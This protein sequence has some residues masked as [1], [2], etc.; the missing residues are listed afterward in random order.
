MSI[1]YSFEDIVAI[2]SCSV[3]LNKNSSSTTLGYLSNQLSKEIR[4]DPRSVWK[5]NFANLSKV[6]LIDCQNRNI[7]YVRVQPFKDKFGALS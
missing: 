7:V 1:R 2:S 4:S 5:F 6:S 3:V